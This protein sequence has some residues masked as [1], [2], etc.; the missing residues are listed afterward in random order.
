MISI[1]ETILM[2]QPR[3][4]EGCG[5]RWQKIKSQENQADREEKGRRYVVYS[6]ER[7]ERK[8]G[9]REVEYGHLGED[10][11][12]L[13]LRA[14]MDPLQARLHG[15]VNFLQALITAPDALLGPTANLQQLLLFLHLNFLLVV[16]ISFSIFVI[17]LADRIF[18]ALQ[19]QPQEIQE[20]PNAIL[21][22]TRLD[23][24]RCENE[25]TINDQRRNL[26]NNPRSQLTIKLRLQSLI[27][28]LKRGDLNLPNR[29]GFNRDKKF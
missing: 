16:V 12:F 29:G 3:Y 7:A 23:C 26:S 4:T 18:L 20:K 14:A 9:G 21:G 1:P 27:V 22:K 5:S 17:F 25:S 28:V 19:L 2:S 13:E 10:T 11:T 8:T 24:E 15:S 6:R